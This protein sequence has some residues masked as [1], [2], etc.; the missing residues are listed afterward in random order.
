MIKNFLLVLALLGTSIIGTAQIVINEYSCSNLNTQLDNFNNYE[1]WIELY[2][3][4]NSTV[5]LG[6]Y[7]LS[8]N[9]AQPL[10]WAIPEQYSGTGY[11]LIYASGLIL[12]LVQATINFKPPKLNL[13]HYFMSQPVPLLIQW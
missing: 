5:N 4:G 6:G 8:D 9:A 3:K 13:N 11:L 2:N 7:Y 1:D 12:L 10:K